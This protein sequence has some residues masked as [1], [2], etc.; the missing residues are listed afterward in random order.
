MYCGKKCGTTMKIIKQRCSLHGGWRTTDQGVEF[1]SRLLTF[2]HNAPS[3]LHHHQD[4][5]GGSTWVRQQNA[6]EK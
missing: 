2:K 1:Y 4:A 6:A 3:P 5:P